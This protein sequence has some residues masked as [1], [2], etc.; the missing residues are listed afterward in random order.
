MVTHLINGNS[1]I[2]KTFKD[3]VFQANASSISSIF[4]NAS[5]R[6]HLILEEVAPDWTRRCWVTWGISEISGLEKTSEE[7]FGAIL[8]VNVDKKSNGIVY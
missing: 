6:D 7:G 3:H 5:D 1:S 8:R 4:S 2:F